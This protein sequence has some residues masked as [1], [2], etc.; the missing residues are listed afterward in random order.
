[1]S[2]QGTS[3]VLFSLADSFVREVERYKNRQV[4]DERV[5]HLHHRLEQMRQISDHI[6]KLVNSQSVLSEVMEVNIPRKKLSG[7]R[8]ALARLMTDFNADPDAIIQPKAFE[9]ELFVDTL[10]EID[11]YLMRVWQKI[12]TPEKRTESILEAAEGDPSSSE[13]A[14]RVRSFLSDLKDRSYDLPKTKAEVHVV[15]KLMDECD[16]LEAAG[17]DE[18]V[19]RF[20][21]ETRS[22]YGASLKKLLDNKK[23]L[24]WLKQKDRASSFHVKRS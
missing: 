10:D 23:V 15:G 3:S 22:F 9:Q 16:R 6:E 11:V 13:T 7:R 24:D 19:A 1:M 8:R 21:E 20:L 17:F 14:K 4:I 12:T 2:K 5:N 18:E